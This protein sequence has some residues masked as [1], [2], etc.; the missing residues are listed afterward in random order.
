MTKTITADTITD[1]QIR[2][3]R[4]EALAAG[5][6]KQVD[7]CNRALADDTIDQDGNLIAF[8]EMS[9]E[10]AREKCADAIDAA[11]AMN[12]GYAQAAL[13]VAQERS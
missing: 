11:Q 2:Q 8:A 7:L 1:K 3:L 12:D 5:D 4:E 10:A 6:Y 9:A 13:D